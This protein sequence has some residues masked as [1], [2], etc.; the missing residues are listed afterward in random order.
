[1]IVKSKHAVGLVIID[2][3]HKNVEIHA[4][5]GLVYDTF[6]F[7]GTETRFLGIDD[8]SRTKIACKSGTVFMFVLTLCAPVL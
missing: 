4:A 6:T 2:Y 7:T 1:M 5:H 3:I 8:I